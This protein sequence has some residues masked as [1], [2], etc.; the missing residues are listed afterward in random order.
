L[1]TSVTISS[2]RCTLVKVKIQNSIDALC[3]WV[4]GHNY[5]AYDPGDGQLSPLRRLAF[6]NVF[7]K[8]LLTAAVLRVPFN[9]RPWIGIQPHTS[10]KGM[11]Y[12]AW[13]YVKMF[14]QT[15]DSRFAGRARS[16]LDWLMQHRAPNHEQYCWGNH[17]DF[18]TRGGTIPAHEP[19]IVWSSLIGQAFFEA[20][21]VLGDDEYLDVAASVADWILTLPRE[22]SRSGACL[23]YVAFKQSSIH[24]SNMLGAA[25]LACVGS[26]TKQGES[27]EVAKAAMEYSCS[28]L[29]QDG[30]W[31]YGESPM[32]HWIDNFHTGYNLDSLK[33]YCDATGD[34]R[35]EEP[36]RHA[37]DYFKQNF[38][39]TNGRPTY[40]HDR[41]YP[42]DI[43]CAAQAIDT[44]SFFADKDDGALDLAQRVAVWTMDNMQDPDGHFYY[45]DLGRIKIRTPMLHWGQGTMFKALAHLL[46]N[47]GQHSACPGTLSPAS[48]AR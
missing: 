18:T 36:M 17:F 15:G 43:Q 28:R 48:Y 38:F 2:A 20:Y 26:L 22:Q 8:R 27:L 1:S 31:F 40:Y 11:G 12:M 29:N 37:F 16:C 47:I 6:G 33:R 9:I 4:E 42:T 19:T 39:E 34:L 25:L 23:S 7:L 24:N 46:K 45:R 35:Y 5:E 14:A 10:T 32:Y 13:G 41:V 3:A 21:Q 30:S 44:L